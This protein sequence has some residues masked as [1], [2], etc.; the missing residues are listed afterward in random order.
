MRR[1]GLRAPTLSRDPWRS[2]LDVLAYIISAYK[3][4]DQ[5]ARLTERLT[6]QRTVVY[7]HVDKKTDD[8]EYDRLARTLGARPRVHL[9]ERHMCHW[10]GFGHV[11]A[12]L[13]GI[14]ALL[15]SGSDFQ[16]LVLL[17]GQDYPIKPPA[18]IERFFDEH[19]GISFM[20]YSKLPSG[21]WDPRGGLDRI[22][23]RHWRW[24]GPHIRLPWKRRFPAGL[25][26]Y[27]GGAYWN[28]SRACVEHVARFVES[29]PDVVDF[30]RH[31]DIPDELLFQTVLMNSELA[32]SVVNDNL[33][34][35][36]WT[37]GP[38]P[39]LLEARDLP[40]LRAS[41][42]LFARKFDVFHDAEILDLV[43]TELL[44]EPERATEL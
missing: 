24:R 33:R 23:Y 8:A 21:W 39:A 28:L 22:E 42:K 9:L 16:H 40:A 32:G 13:K 43:D 2:E 20:A 5:V 19:R 18:E 41:P 6:T 12:T 7:I 44:R 14:D 26:P 31:V 37:R 38:R 29:R 1:N 15:A 30:F 34:Y 27:G 35:I 11:R 4:L 17:T 3:N 25:T 36:D 10:G